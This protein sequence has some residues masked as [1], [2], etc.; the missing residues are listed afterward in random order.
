MIS[1]HAAGRGRMTL[2]VFSTL[3]SRV[4][5]RV[6]PAQSGCGGRALAGWG[7]PGRRP[8]SEQGS[9]KTVTYLKRSGY[10]TLLP[11]GVL[12][13]LVDV[14]V[15]AL[16]LPALG[17]QESHH[18]AVRGAVFAIGIITLVGVLGDRWH[19]SSGKHVL[20]DDLLLLKIGARFHT[21]VP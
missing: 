19:I 18:L 8:A 1:E 16:I 10:G 11:F 2:P 20:T 13:L 9:G 7:G 21:A 5:T 3:P 14:P 4:P 15:S 12:A 6:P 17:V